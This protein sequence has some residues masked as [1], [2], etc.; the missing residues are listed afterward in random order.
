MRHGI[1]GNTLNRKT[2]HRKA[3]VRDIAK[4]T[5][6]QQRISTTKAKAKEARKLVDKLITLGKK[7]NL[8]AKR[9]AYTILCDHQLVSHLFTVTASRF[10]ERAGGYTRIIGLGNRKGDNA[11]MVFLELTEKSEVVISKPRSSA[12]KKAKSGVRAEVDGDKESGTK[13]ID[14]VNEKIS[15][16]ETK[17]EKKPAGEK[18][19]QTKK[20]EAAKDIKPK[21]F[22][23][24]IRKMF[25][26]KS[27]EK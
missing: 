13:K 12:S 11:Q 15:S 5:L 7:G 6:I 26:R 16:E 2:S 19:K 9:Q 8:A 4:A 23:G 21:K 17:I 25:Q 1:A 18:L 14:K 3:T 27:P 20:T 22:G 10:K 24:N